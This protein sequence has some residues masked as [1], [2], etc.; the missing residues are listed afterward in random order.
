MC[1]CSLG[2]RP[3][4]FDLP[5]IIHRSGRPAKNE[6]GLGAF[7][8]WMTS[9]RHEVDVGGEGSNC[10]NNAQDHPFK[11]STG[12]EATQL[13]CQTH[14]GLQYHGSGSCYQDMEQCSNFTLH[15]HGFVT[16]VL[17]RCRN[18]NNV[19]TGN[20]HMSKWNVNYNS[21]SSTGELPSPFLF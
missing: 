1:P 14:N 16:F 20:F 19:H 6:E 10:Q 21:R 5:A 17:T 4:P 3:P 13:P 8:T 12:T 18:E 11:H 2:P 15:D 9:G 7:I